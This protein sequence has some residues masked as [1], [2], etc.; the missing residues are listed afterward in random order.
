M[1]PQSKENAGHMPVI[2]SGLPVVRPHPPRS[3]HSV[4]VR[5]LLC[6]PFVGPWTP[7][8]LVATK[9]LPCKGL[10]CWGPYE[11]VWILCP[12]WRCGL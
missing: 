3:V 11:R 7:V 12:D 10:S 9:M 5:F 1:E 6:G 4:T 2:C 8:V